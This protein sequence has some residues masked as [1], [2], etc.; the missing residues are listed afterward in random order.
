MVKGN[1]GT[2][3]SAR[4]RITPTT[5]PYPLPRWTQPFRDDNIHQTHTLS[6]GHRIQRLSYNPQSDAI[7]VVQYYSRFATNDPENVQTYHYHLWCPVLQRYTKV[8]QQV[9][10]LFVWAMYACACT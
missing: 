9:R 4:R 10:I 5:R 8:T 3:V 2:L 7:E 6:M 1:A